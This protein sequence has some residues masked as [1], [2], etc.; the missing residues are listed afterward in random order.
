MDK[1]EIFRYS[2]VDAGNIPAR[3]GLH[4]AAPPF[5]LKKPSN[6]EIQKWLLNVQQSRKIS[7]N[8]GVLIWIAGL[9]FQT[10][11]LS[12]PALMMTPIDW[13]FFGLNSQ[14]W[15]RVIVSSGQTKVFGAFSPWAPQILRDLQHHHDRPWRSHVDDW[16]QGLKGLKGRPI[17]SSRQRWWQSW[18]T[19]AQMPGQCGGQGE[20]V[21]DQWAGAMTGICYFWDDVCF[22]WHTILYLEFSLV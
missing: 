14:S 19:S 15:H 5:W 3:Q 17:P 8:I 16:F 11:F 1:H 21:S 2:C 13:V 6:C 22:W 20:F 12:I 7:K 4:V 10:P 18:E 9:W